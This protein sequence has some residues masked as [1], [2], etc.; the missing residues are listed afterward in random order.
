MVKWR[1]G[2]HTK[3][4]Q[5]VSVP[6]LLTERLILQYPQQEDGRVRTLCHVA[7]VRHEPDQSLAMSYIFG[8]FPA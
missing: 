2:H 6:P 3:F 4:Y 5:G 7:K 1:R 8:Y